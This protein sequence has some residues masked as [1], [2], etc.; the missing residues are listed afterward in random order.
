MSSN[1]DGGRK[2][3]NGNLEGCIQILKEMGRIE[4]LV[5]IDKMCKMAISSPVYGKKVKPQRQ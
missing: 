3:G 1:Q 4:N 2:V 5:R